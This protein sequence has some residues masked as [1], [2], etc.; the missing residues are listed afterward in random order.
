MQNDRPAASPDGI[1]RLLEIMAKLRDPESGCPWDLEQSFETIAP[2]TIEEAYEVADAIGRRDM[3]ELKD[4]LGD[5]L[6]QVVFYA[7]MAREDGAFD[8]DAIAQG[9]SDKMVRR[10]P[11]VF[12]EMNVET[13]SQM[14]RLWEDQKAEERRRK[15]VGQQAS[16]LDG[17]ILA[18]PALTRALKLQKRAAR[19]GFDWSEAPPI[20]D[21]IDE[22]IA[23]LRAVLEEEDASRQ[24]D[25]REDELGDL[26]F[27]VTN[28][29]R[30]LDVDPEGALRRANAKFERRFRRIEALLSEE[31]QEPSDVSLDHMEALWRQAKAEERK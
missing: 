2:H 22:E 21:K 5:L 16:A 15:A 29:A 6:F 24:A 25:R 3:A 26:L 30:H 8:F 19:V 1:T 14:N 9:V 23:E 10:H 13:S 18:L 27:A 28:L 17:I 4:E 20:L 11:H 7:Q 12:G 31:G